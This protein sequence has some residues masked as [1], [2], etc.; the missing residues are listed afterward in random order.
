MLRT[1]SCA[2]TP[3]ME[4]FHA[5]R[6]RKVLQYHQG[7]RLHSTRR[8]IQGRVRARLG[9]RTRRARHFEREP[10]DLV[11]ARARAER[12]DVRRRSE[13]RLIPVAGAAFAIPAC[14]QLFP[15]PQAPVGDRSGAGRGID[16]TKEALIEMEGTVSEVLPDTRYRVTL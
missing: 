16:V 3:S 13:S 14:R 8:Q 10:E 5:Y 4:R 2:A 1:L 9:S 6:Y 7:V 15:Q 12:Q 11:R